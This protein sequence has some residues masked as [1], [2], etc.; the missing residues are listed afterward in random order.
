MVLP[1]VRLDK[2]SSVGRKFGSLKKD[3]PTAKM[4]TVFSGEVQA[5]AV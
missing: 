4:F 1:S 2:H 3:E 5:D